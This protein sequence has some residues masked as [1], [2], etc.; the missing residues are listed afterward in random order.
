MVPVR[1]GLPE[2][3]VNLVILRLVDDTL[4]NDVALENGIE[5]GVLVT[6]RADPRALDRERRMVT[7]GSQL[8]VAPVPVPIEFMDATSVDALAC[9]IYITCWVPSPFNM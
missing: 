7:A 9:P 6:A 1:A 8:G 2:K 5:E 3:L 4:G